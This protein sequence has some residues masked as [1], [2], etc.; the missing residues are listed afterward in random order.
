MRGINSGYSA[1]PCTSLNRSFVDCPVDKSGYSHWMASEATGQVDDQAASNK[2]WKDIQKSA[3]CRWAN[4]RLKA[5]DLEINDLQTDLSDGVRLIRLAESLAGVK[6][7]QRYNAK[8]TTRTQKLENVTVCLQFLE[9]EQKVRIINI[10]KQDGRILVWRGRRGA[11]V[12]LKRRSTQK[13][14]GSKISQVKLSE[15]FF[16]KLYVFHF[17]VHSGSLLCRS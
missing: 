14:L 11:E 17:L 9:Q 6:I 13:A 3:F 8:P 15:I 7:K 12:W 2:E 10:G 16:L 4:E 5:V 1:E